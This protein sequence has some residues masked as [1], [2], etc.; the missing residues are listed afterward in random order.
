MNVLITGGSSG[1]GEAITRKFAKEGHSV[2]F[3][4]NQSESNAKKIEADHKN[5]FAIKC[6]FKSLDEVEALKTKIATIELDLLINNAYSGSFM[7][8][9]FYKISTDD[10]LT[11]FQDNV[12]PTISI[13]QAAIG[14]FRKK[15]GG[16]II[17]ILT[18]ALVN[19][20]PAGSSIYVGNKAYLKQLSKV[21]ASENIRYNITSNTV[22]PSFM[23]TNFTNDI[24]ERVIEQIK[25]SN[26]SKKILTTEEVAEAVLFLSSASVQINGIDMIINSG[27]NII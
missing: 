4:Y 21:W 11:E 15:K 27:T 16:K 6:N 18:S 1:L 23:L 5:A 17:T 7:K 3:T 2:Y 24:D 26:P 14:Y 12:I 22:S 25:D 8:S 20:P 19:T 13:T 9:H 10:F